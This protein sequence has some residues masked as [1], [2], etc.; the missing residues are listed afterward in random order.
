MCLVDVVPDLASSDTPTAQLL[1]ALFPVLFNTWVRALFT[2]QKHRSGDRT[3]LR[4]FAMRLS[5][6]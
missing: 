5:A 3:V 6:T 4:V 2:K 1:D